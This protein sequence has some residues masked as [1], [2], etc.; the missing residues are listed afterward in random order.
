[1]LVVRLLIKYSLDIKQALDKIIGCFSEEALNLLDKQSTI[2]LNF[3]FL[4]MYSTF[5][6]DVIH[7][8]MRGAEW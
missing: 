5:D 6:K 4:C 1:M 8:G 3:M 2:S 7:D